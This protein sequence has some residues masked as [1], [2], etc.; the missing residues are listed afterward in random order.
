MVQDPL[1]KLGMWEA[2]TH[3]TE[4]Q[5][6]SSTL[7]DDA[8]LHLEEGRT[9]NVSTLMTTHSMEECEALCNR[10]AIL[11]RGCLVCVGTPIEL[12]RRFCPYTVV[13]VSSCPCHMPLDQL[14]LF[15]HNFEIV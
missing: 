3:A 14:L 6:L 7:R 2:V 5:K 15:V 4:S 1:A 8:Q 13:K 10:I 12:K 11:S 9:R